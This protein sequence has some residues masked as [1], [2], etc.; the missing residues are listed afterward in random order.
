[1]ESG[2]EAAFSFDTGKTDQFTYSD[3]L[4]FINELKI[5]AMIHPGSFEMKSSVFHELPDGDY[6]KENWELFWQ[7]YNLLQFNEYFGIEREHAEKESLPLETILAKFD[8]A[9]HAIVKQLIENKIEI[10]LDSDF[11]LMKDEDII[12]DAELGSE[13]KKFFIKPFNEESRV[14]FIE[15]GYIEFTIE[16]FNISKI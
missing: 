15:A 8:T 12:A 6:E 3:S 11:V 9:L 5:V 13:S 14:K 16:N 2:R 1:L 7:A 10:N 4:T